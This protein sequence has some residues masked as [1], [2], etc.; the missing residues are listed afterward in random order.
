MERTIRFASLRAPDARDLQSMKTW[1]KQH[2]PLSKEERAHLLNGTDFVALV[3]KQEE[4][5]LDKIV[6]R[7]LLTC[8]PRRDV[9]SFS[10]LL[11]PNLLTV[12]EHLYLAGATSYQRQSKPSFTQQAPH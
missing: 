3:E 11:G 5:W 7:A 10:S 1:I 2:Q 9:G 6:E 12:P 4:G 8:F